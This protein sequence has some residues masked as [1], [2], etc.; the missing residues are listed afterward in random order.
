MR[1][2]VWLVLFLAQVATALACPGAKGTGLTTGRNSCEIRQRAV[3]AAIETYAK[4]HDCDPV[5]H[6]VRGESPSLFV[7]HEPRSAPA[8]CFG[9]HHP[10]NDP[11]PAAVE[12]PYDFILYLRN[13]HGLAFHPPDCTHDRPGR[14][15]LRATTFGDGIICLEHGDLTSPTRL[16]PREQL[17]RAGLRDAGVLAGA[18]STAVQRPYRQ[19]PGPV[20]VALL[21]ACLLIGLCWRL[22]RSGQRTAGRVCVDVLVAGAHW[23]LWWMATA[24]HSGHSETWTPALCGAACLG[25]LAAGL[26]LLA[27]H[28]GAMGAA[29]LGH[30]KPGAPPAPAGPAPDPVW[31]ALAQGLRCA[32]CSTGDG[33]QDW[34]ACPSC[35]TSHH[36]DCWEFQDGCAV[37]GC[38]MAHGRW[39]AGRPGR[40]S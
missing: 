12:L 1:S 21:A 14:V 17:R 31:I 35:E 18:S 30:L 32:V 20:P 11:G 29:V 16:S 7:E 24:F 25:S 4:A 38:S 2:T 9:L 10:P 27:H 5:W 23:V 6:L 28:M 26:A 33:P 40:L 15:S 39:R 22:W 8:Q 37:Y 13:H 36:T 3:L 19:H 34:V